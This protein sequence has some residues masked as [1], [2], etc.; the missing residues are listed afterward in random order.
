MALDIASM[1]LLLLVA[2]VP[3]VGYLIWVRNTE[4]CRREPYSALIGVMVYGG[5]FAVAAAVI[6]ETLVQMALYLPG[7][8]LSRGFGIFG[9]F[10]PTLEAILLAVIIAPVVEELVKAT[11]VFTVYG[12]LNEIEDGI[13]YG[14]AVGL[15]FAV[16]ENVLYFTVAL[17]Q[18]VDVL[19]LTVIV[20]SLT[21][22][23]LHL[24]AT[25]IS[26]YG[27]SRARVLGAHGRSAGWLRYVGI[28]I[29]LHAS[30]N[31]IASLGDIFPQNA[32]LLALIGLVIVFVLAQ[33]AFGIMRRRIKQLDLATPCPPYQP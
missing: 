6:L 13:I 7:S 32:D 21:S 9:P 11:G 5:T 22:M 20:R 23:V 33:T 12:R 15:G 28:A 18:G 29:V 17:S 14:A 26:G 16:T 3:A 1:A 4:T 30:F 19:L 2:I 10:D 25:S 27:I 24:S 31:L 8:P